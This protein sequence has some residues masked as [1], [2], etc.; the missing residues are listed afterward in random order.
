MAPRP[1]AITYHQYFGFSRMTAVNAMP[2]RIQIW[3]PPLVMS[4]ISLMVDFRQSSAALLTDVFAAVE[5][6]S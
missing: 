4:F 2:S 1:A 3:I 5:E 6:L